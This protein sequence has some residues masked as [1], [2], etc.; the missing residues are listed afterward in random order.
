MRTIVV[1]PARG[2]SKTVP[3]KNLADLGGRPVIGWSIESA[4][5]AQAIGA[6]DRV[7]V[8]TDDPEIARMAKRLGAELPFMRPDELATDEISIIPVLMHAA[9]TFDGFGW[10]TDA[11][12]SLQDSERE[13]I[14]RALEKHRN[15]RKHAAEE[16]GISERTLYRKIKEYDLK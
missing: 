5:A 9:D 10:N 11:I 4:L 7:V 2:G 3:R 13:L 8:S 12:L 1:I 14:R 6:V 16:L 15:K